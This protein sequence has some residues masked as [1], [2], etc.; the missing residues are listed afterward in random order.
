[1]D[2]QTHGGKRPPVIH[3]VSWTDSFSL[4]LML[5]SVVCRATISSYAKKSKGKDQLPQI[6][7]IMSSL[8]KQAQEAIS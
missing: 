6:Y 5:L 2:G 7:T 4:C 1:M 3:P 8:L